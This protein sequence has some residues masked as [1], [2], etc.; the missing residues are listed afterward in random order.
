MNALDDA[1]IIKVC[2]IS[3]VSA[4]LDSA[5]I[6]HVA[7]IKILASIAILMLFLQPIHY[8]SADQNEIK[9]HRVNKNK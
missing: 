9:K 6:V 7:D 1:L 3:S 5:S 2:L 4:L 8:R